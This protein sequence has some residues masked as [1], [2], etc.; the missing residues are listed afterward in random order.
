MTLYSQATIAGADG[1]LEQLLLLVITQKLANANYV[2]SSLETD[3][4]TRSVDW[5]LQIDTKISENGEETSA[6]FIDISISLPILPYDNVCLESVPVDTDISRRIFSINPTNADS[7]Y[8][9]REPAYALNSYPA[10]CPAYLDDFSAVN[11]GKANSLERRL[12]SLCLQIY[13]YKRWEFRYN[14]IVGLINMRELET[15]ETPLVADFP[16]LADLEQQRLDLVTE[17]TTSNLAL[18]LDLPSYFVSTA[19]PPI[20]IGSGG[21]GS[22]QALDG[23]FGAADPSIGDKT[24]LSEFMKD[25]LNSTDSPGGNFGGSSAQQNISGKETPTLKDC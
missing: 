15:I 3:F 14:Y 23:Y 1:L 12:M 11:M 17:I 19:P 18:P 9:A 13:G 5:S 16:T 22:A 6:G 8:I 2:P 25:L 24:S 21:N 7:L 20:S 10:Y 4:T